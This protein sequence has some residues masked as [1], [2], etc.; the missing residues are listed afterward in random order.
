MADHTVW[1]VRRAIDGT[2]YAGTYP[3][4]LFK[5]TDAGENW[6]ARLFRESRRGTR[7]VPVEPTMASQA[8][9]IVTDAD[10]PDVPAGVEVGGIMYSDDAGAS[11][12]FN[13]G[14]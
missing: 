1:Q 13:A 8:R 10:N 6:K 5:S 14:R 11:W 9:A 3:A 12:R 2:L 4:E 7:L